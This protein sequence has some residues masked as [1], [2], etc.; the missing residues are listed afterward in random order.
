MVDA[1]LQKGGNIN[2]PDIYGHSPLHIAAHYGIF[3]LENNIN[4]TKINQTII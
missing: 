2:M 3:D 1:L 4:G